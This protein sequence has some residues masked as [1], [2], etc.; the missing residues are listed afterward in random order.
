MKIHA[1]FW[2]FRREAKPFMT[3]LLDGLDG[4][5]PRQW[6][7]HGRLCSPRMLF[8]FDVASVPT[9]KVSI[10]NSEPN[11]LKDLRKKL[12]TEIYHVLRKCRIITNVW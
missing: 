8:V 11:P 2:Y 5:L 3:R 9:S 4:L 1:L 12:E 6:I 10:G 7:D